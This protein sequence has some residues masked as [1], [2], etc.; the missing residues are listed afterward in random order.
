MLDWSA[1]I[2]ASSK[3]YN[4]PVK[5]IGNLSTPAKDILGVID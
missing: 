5:C 4:E 2:T 3:T 1:K